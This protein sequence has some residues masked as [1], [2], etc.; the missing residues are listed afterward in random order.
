M[1]AFSDTSLGGSELAL[2]SSGPRCRSAQNEIHSRLAFHLPD[3]S[4]FVVGN[5]AYQV[6]YQGGDG[7]DLTFMVVP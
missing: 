4:T 1:I 2:L 7:N 3:D 6:D 5:N